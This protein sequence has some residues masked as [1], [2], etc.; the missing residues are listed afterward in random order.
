MTSNELLAQ[1]EFSQSF[2]WEKGEKVSL[3]VLDVDGVLTDGGLYYNADGLYLKRFDTQDGL[4][5]KLAEECGIKTAIISGMD[6]E[7]VGQRAKVLG[8][9]ECHTGIQ[10][11]LP[12]LQEIMQANALEWENVAYIGDDWLDLPLFKRA[13]LA[14]APA[15]AQPEVKLM[16]DFVCPLAGGN[17]AVRYAVRHI[18][19]A[20]GLLETALSKWLN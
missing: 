4:G 13:G 19:Q 8:I 5:V 12:K 2:P 16:A 18:L 6:S 9:S 10:Q 15:N 20:R 11:K 7:A 1:A 14:I 3:L 17:G